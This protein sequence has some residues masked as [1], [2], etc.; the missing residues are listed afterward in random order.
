MTTIEAN[1]LA[2]RPPLRIHHLLIWMTL[3][4]AIISGC[5]FFDRHARNGPP[6]ENR[7]IIAGLVLC[8][9]TIAG[10]LTVAGC[11]MYWRR[12]GI[13]FPQSP[14]DW[15][16]TIIAGS[17]ALFCLALGIMLAI[18]AVFGDDDWLGIFYAMVAL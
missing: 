5:L 11:G 18:F 2:D 16:L 6:I 4:A 8:A 3:T 9:I 14:G 15:L 12:K 1:E 17:I 10:D 7:V 13:A